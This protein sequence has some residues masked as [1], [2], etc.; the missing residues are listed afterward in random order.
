MQRIEPETNLT[1]LLMAELAGTRA[2]KPPESDRFPLI[3]ILQNA[4]FGADDAARTGKFH[5]RGAVIVDA[6]DTMPQRLYSSPYEKVDI[7]P[8]PL[9][10]RKRASTVPRALLAQKRTARV[11]APYEAIEIHIEHV[12][13]SM[14]ASLVASGSFEAAWFVS[15][16]D[17]IVEAAATKP[18]GARPDARG[19]QMMMI[20]GAVLG[21]CAVVIALL[22]IV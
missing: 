17:E 5:R 4:A 11:S 15:P 18:D 10:R 22:T 9:A 14:S 2:P 1:N 12:P 6:D 20:G 13:P 19:A 8:I 3:E 21:A 7:A 16:D